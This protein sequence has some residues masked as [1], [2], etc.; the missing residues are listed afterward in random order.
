MPEKNASSFEAK[1]R[2][3]LSKM[4][5]RFNSNDEEFFLLVFIHLLSL[6]PDFLIQ[7]D[8]FSLSR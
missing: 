6:I 2:N 3:V 7:S 4:T 5:K 1:R 8:I